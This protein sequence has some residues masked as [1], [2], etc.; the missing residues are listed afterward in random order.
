MTDIMEGVSVAGF[1]TVDDDD[2]D[3]HWVCCRNDDV[4]LCGKDV[5][6]LPVL[7]FEE[8]SCRACDNLLGTEVCPLGLIC[9]QIN[10]EDH[11]GVD[12]APT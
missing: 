1:P 2:K 4:S 10:E 9:G 6:D 11:A 12:E 7:E 5:M 8:A 3:D